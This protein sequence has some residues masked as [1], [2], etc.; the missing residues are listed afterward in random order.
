MEQT[1]IVT[2]HR[3]KIFPIDAAV[4][5]TSNVRHRRRARTANVSAAQMGGLRVDYLGL[6]LG[7]TVG[8]ASH[9]STV[10]SAKPALV[11]DVVPCALP[12][13]IVG[14]MNGVLVRPKIQD[15]C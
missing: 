4:L 15:V 8:H 13:K 14:P 5:R 11:V 6:A 2:E 10:L 7:L 9:Y 3:M 1:T 12:I